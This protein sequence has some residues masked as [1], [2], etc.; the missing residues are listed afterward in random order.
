ML[1]RRRKPVTISE[2]LRVFLWPRK[3][4]A[5]GLRYIGLRILRLK[6]SPHSIAV[7][8]AAGAASSFTPFFGFHIV[9]AVLLASLFSG[10]LIAAA[11]T[12]ALANPIT[13]PVILTASYELGTVLMGPQLGPIIGNAELTRMI[14]HLELDR[15]WGP[16]FKPMLI[17]SL[18]LSITGALIFY[19]LAY[20][21]VRLFQQRRRRKPSHEIGQS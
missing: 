7:G 8:V 17:G 2:R 13:I 9:L 4:F 20:Q 19:A 6:S 3:G 1:F 11:V 5:R 14:E 10:N 12:T 18:P 15:L 21:A 16:V